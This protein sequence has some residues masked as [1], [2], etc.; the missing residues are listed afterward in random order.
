MSI[1]QPGD[2]IVIAPMGVPNDASPVARAA[3]ILG[4]YVAVADTAERNAIP[5]SS[6]K[7]GMLVRANDGTYYTLGSGL[8][9]SDWTVA[10]FSGSSAA[11]SPAPDYVAT[12]NIALTG[13]VTVDGA[14]PATGKIVLAT[15]QTNAADRLYWVAN[16]AGAWTLATF[17]DTD[18]KIAP[19]LGISSGAVASGSL[20]TG[21]FWYLESGTTLAGAKVW[22]K[23]ATPSLLQ[24]ALGTTLPAQLATQ[25]IGPYV[26]NDATNGRNRADH[27]YVDL[28]TFGG[29]PNG[30]QQTTHTCI[31]G[32]PSVALGSALSY[33]VGQWLMLHQAGAA[34]G[35]A[36][37]GTPIVVMQGTPGTRTVRVKWVA[38][39]DHHGYTAASAATTITNAN[40]DATSIWHVNT[41]GATFTR[42]A[43]GGSVIV[44]VSDSSIFTVGRP[45]T[46]SGDFY[47]C[48]K[49]VGI[50]DGTHVTL[51]YLGGGVAGP[52]TFAV[53]TP[54]YTYQYTE[55]WCPD[56]PGADKYICYVEFDNSGVF[57]YY[58][59]II[60]HPLPAVLS[61]GAYFHPASIRI[62]TSTPPTPPPGIPA[63]APSAAVPNALRTK[64]TALVGTT[65]T[66]SPAPT[67]SATGKVAE[68]CNKIP[69]EDACASDL[70]HSVKLLLATGDYYCA[71][72]LDLT[73]PAH[74]LGSNAGLQAIGSRLL[75]RDGCGLST[76]NT[77]SARAWQPGVRYRVNDR[78]TTDSVINVTGT[79]VLTVCGNGQTWAV[80]T[81]A[82]PAWNNTLGSTT[83]DANGN[84]WT[85]NALGL[86]SQGGK[87]VHIGFAATGSTAPCQRSMQVA[88]LRNDTTTGPLACDKFVA[89]ATY[90]T[91][92]YVVPSQARATGK[93]YRSV[94]GGIA[95]TEPASWGRVVGANTSDGTLNWECLD[96]QW[97]QG[98]LIAQ[99]TPVDFERCQAKNAWGAGVAIEAASGPTGGN[100][101]NCEHSCWDFR[102]LTGSN[103]F[104]RGSDANAITVYRGEYNSMFDS[105]AVLAS[106][107]QADNL[108]AT[109][110]ASFYGMAVESPLSNGG[111]GFQNL[112]AG[113][114]QSMGRL[115]SPYIEHPGQG[116]SVVD[117]NQPSVV[118][119]G[120][121]Y[122]IRDGATAKRKSGPAGT[123]ASTTAST[124]DLVLDD[125]A[126][127]QED[128]DPVPK[129]WKRYNGDVTKLVETRLMAQIDFGA[130]SPSTG[131]QLMFL[132]AN[133]QLPAL[134]IDHYG[135]HGRGL[136]FPEGLTS[137][138]DGLATGYTNTARLRFANA[139]PTVGTFRIGDRFIWTADQARLEFRPTVTGGLAPTP[140]ASLHLYTNGDIVG[141]S[142]KVFVM[143]SAFGTSAGSLSGTFGTAVPGDSFVEGGCC[144]ICWSGADPA[145]RAV[146]NWSAGPV[147]LADGDYQAGSGLLLSA[148]PVR[149]LAA[150]TANRTIDLLTTG[151]IAGDGFELRN[152]N[153]VAFTWTI[154]SGSGGSVAIVLPANTPCKVRL[155]Y[156]G[157]A[158]VVDSFQ[159]LTAYPR[160]NPIRNVSGTTDTPT[161][162][163]QATVVTATNAAL[164]TFTLNTK[165]AGT[166]IPFYGTGAAG[167][168]FANGTATIET[169][170][171]SN[172]A[173][174][175]Y[176]RRVA[177]WRTTT[178]VSIG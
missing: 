135:V 84:V 14:T 94:A 67:S 72:N 132:M 163:D 81:T 106:P 159:L 20:G 60:A 1:T 113:S 141:Q 166:S 89:G 58:G 143:I 76:F 66:V 153:D 156:S 165:P 136:V 34:H 103:L 16:T 82:A 148:G 13:S 123:S 142:G 117:Y 164:T 140:W 119:P 177:Y 111:V 24:D 125:A 83:T 161:A 32:N 90:A 124:P 18:A 93:I 118:G 80:S 138:I 88:D 115:I 174:S 3:A 98:A 110:D 137:Q 12:S 10:T 92:A 112:R 120:G 70:V 100:A 57:T 176:Q 129:T 65:A 158:W 97:L 104:A 122:T 28:R 87:I 6:R 149:D 175:Q 95:G 101:N 178:N 86:T 75:F 145:F 47:Q 50:T 36:T 38:A 43:A 139:I 15:A 109:Q 147:A 128:Y 160:I 126:T 68:V 78:V 85:Y 8:T 74:V 42:P 59:Q 171:P 99:Y 169:A 77:Y 61:I 40:I 91:G 44:Q 62:T 64:I 144:W 130:Y 146:P 29:N 37:P 22:K 127:M 19:L 167:F 35:L 151:A 155:V 157:S 23:V 173:A 27:A 108:F 46:V 39:T 102:G 121:I 69:F 170:L 17:N 63:T 4:G 5:M 41:T 133:S 33:K 31:N 172:G 96:L 52:I 48:Y 51:Q 134:W 30:V 11:T 26:D 53:S 150:A 9:N 114:V 107:Y 116:A 105:Q 7:E 71:G 154:N 2:V 162:A 152:N 55:A 73:H 131:R 168:T 25:H 21:S 79:W 45:V 56:V 49:C 54:L